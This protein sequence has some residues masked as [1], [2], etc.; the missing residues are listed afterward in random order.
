MLIGQCIG[1]ASGAF[2][3]GTPSY[4]GP[5]IVPELL[6]GFTKGGGAGTWTLPEGVLQEGDIVNLVSVSA[7]GGPQPTNGTPSGFTREVR[8]YSA[9][10][11]V[12]INNRVI[13]ATPPT[14][15]QYLGNQNG[16]FQTAN[17]FF[18]VR[19]ASGRA[20]GL[21]GAARTGVSHEP[22][23]ITTSADNSLMVAINCVDASGRLPTAYP[24]D[25][26][27]YTQS[28]NEGSDA[29]PHAAVSIATKTAAF[30]GSNNFDVGSFDLVTAKAVQ[31]Y[32]MA[33]TPAA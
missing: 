11:L 27:N 15:L 33:F 17:L 32:T 30:A 29:H 12:I 6:Q 8:L 9:D 28:T 18:V 20:G 5:F 7:G 19:G 26:D 16:S 2:V 24:S 14:T 21:P 13:G 3:R 23:P 25:R 1:V 31:D 22:R 4:E 10:P